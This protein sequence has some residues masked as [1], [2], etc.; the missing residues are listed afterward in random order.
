ML[1][2]GLRKSGYTGKMVGVSVNLADLDSHD[3]AVF[4]RKSFST[5]H[6]GYGF[7]SLYNPESVDVPLNAARPL[8]YMD[9]ILRSP[10][11]RSIMLP[12]FNQTGRPAERPGRKYWAC[13]RRS[14]SHAPWMRIRSYGGGI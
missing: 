9:E 2:R 10:K 7:P 6:T 3:D 13:R 11:A 5:G 4:A 12:N 8:R 1:Q 14:A